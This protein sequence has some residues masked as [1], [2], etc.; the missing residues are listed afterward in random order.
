MYRDSLKK[1]T[2]KVLSQSQVSKVRAFWFRLYLT[3]G[4]KYHSSF[5]NLSVIYTK[6]FLVSQRN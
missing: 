4:K 1:W 3:M 6:I 5:I 2:L